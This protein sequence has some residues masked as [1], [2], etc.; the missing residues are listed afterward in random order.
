VGAGGDLI[1]PGQNGFVFPF[2]DVGSLAA[3]LKDALTSP[4]RLRELGDAARR[5]MSSWAPSDNINAVVRAVA[6]ACEIKKG[7]GHGK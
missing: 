4:K 3:I 7:A 6:L 2:G 5:R 1:T